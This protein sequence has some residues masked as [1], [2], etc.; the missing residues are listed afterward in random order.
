MDADGEVFGV[1]EEA[2][3][4]GILAQ[5]VGEPGH[6]IEPAPVDGEGAHAVEGRGLPVDG[7]G[8]R[9]GGTSGELILADLVG[10][11][12]GGPRVAA[13]EGGEMG[14]PAAGG[15]VGPEL[16]DQ[17]VLEVGVD[18]VPQGRPLRA[19]CARGRCRRAGDVGAG[20]PSRFVWV[21]GRGSSFP[22]A[23]GGGRPSTFALV[24]A[25][26]KG[27]VR[28]RRDGDGTR[29]VRAQASPTG[30][31]A[32]H[33]SATIRRAPFED[34]WRRHPD[35]GGSRVHISPLADRARSLR[36]ES[37]GCDDRGVTLMGPEALSE[38]GIDAGRPRGLIE[39]VSSAS[40]PPSVRG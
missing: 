8:G 5:P 35:G 23:T 37:V 24:G 34:I 21:H 14:G 20:W 40:G 22:A 30:R 27:N 15:A 39:K 9:P 13:E 16:P 26:G 33:V 10:G 4:G 1:L 31:P 18:E 6:G 12:G 32:G 38:G 7:A 25:T 19:E 3:A 17:V 2:L 11:Q 28:R 29:G 36:D